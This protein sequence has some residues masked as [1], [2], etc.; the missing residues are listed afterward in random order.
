M[1]LEG[2]RINE[3]DRE[4]AVLY[5]STSGH[6]FGHLFA[7]AVEAEDFMLW[8]KRCGCDDVRRLDVGQEFDVWYRR[9]LGQPSS[10]P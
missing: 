2:T 7:S 5:C 3:C 4:G 8:A 9:W 6:A 10:R 1:I